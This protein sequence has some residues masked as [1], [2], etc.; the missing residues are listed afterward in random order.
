MTPSQKEGDK[1][2]NHTHKSHSA[3]TCRMKTKNVL[4]IAIV[5]DKGTKMCVDPWGN[6]AILNAEGEGG[7]GPPSGGGSE[8]LVP[9][10][11]GG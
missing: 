5:T 8:Q 9:D 11:G 7:P 10:S 1:Y 4:I 2:Y 6:G 3:T